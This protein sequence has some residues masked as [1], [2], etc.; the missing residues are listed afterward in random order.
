MR[1]LLDR[2][3]HISGRRST[4]RR[5]VIAG[6]TVFGAMAYIVAVN[7]AILA[8]T[9][10]DRHDMVLTTI[11]GAVAGTLIMGLWARLPIALAPA[12]SSNVLF[13]QVIVQQAHVGPRT[14]FT[15]VLFS[16]LC[17]TLL[18]LTRLRQK[19]SQGFPPSIILGIQVAIGVFIARVGLISGGVAVPTPGGLGF[20]SL[21][22]PRVLLVLGGILVC[23]ILSVIRLPAG[24]LLTILA[25][26]IAGAMISHD[27]Q[28]ITRLPDHWMD[29]PH[30][31]IHL[32]LPFDFSDFFAHI[33]LLL[34]ITLYVLLSD[35]FDA[36]GTLLSVAHRAGLCGTKEHP[37]LDRRAYASDGAGSI[38]GA[39]LG[40]CTV[41]AYV[42][43]LAGAEV[44]GR[45]GLS[46]LVVA[47]LFGLS[48]F[49]WPLITS[50]PAIAT[51]P[52]LVLVGLNMMGGLARLPSAQAEALPPLCMLLIAGVTGN[53][54]LSLACGMLLYTGL[55]LALR[56]FEQLTWTVLG[57]DAAF[58]CYMVL[59]SRF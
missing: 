50:I 7:P 27:G 15:V 56:R 26:T 17:F 31:P 49:L 6:L 59:Q 18:S 43:N 44:G 29:W 19:I 13:A 54:M 8:A 1:A 11:A 39:M 40:T 45:T 33:G 42:E 46:A 35:F 12:M 53:F 32:L 34:P 36:T 14:A 30:Y 38:V 41:S 3:F 28:K 48:S 10:L 55:A 2:Y 16:G 58:V 52:I 57:L 21:A 20:G 37:D 4:V 51:A 47:V 9:G 23:A 5:E 22:D 24:L 25:L